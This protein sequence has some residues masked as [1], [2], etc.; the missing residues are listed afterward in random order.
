[1]YNTSMLRQNDFIV[2]IPIGVRFTLQYNASGNLE[3]VYVG[4]D[5]DR[6]DV[7]SDYL[8][9]FTQNKLVPLHINITGGT[10]WVKVVSYTQPIPKSCGRLPICV[11]SDLLCGLKENPNRYKFYGVYVESTTKIMQGFASIRQ[12]LSVSKFDTLNGWLA[13]VKPSSDTIESWLHSSSYPFVA[14][15]TMFI[16]FRGND[17]RF[18]PT[19]L[20]QR[21]IVDI[22]PYVDHHGYHN[23]DVKFND[24]SVT[25]PVSAK[26]IY[27]LAVGSVVIMD[28]NMSIMYSDTRPIMP[29]LAVVCDYC[30][31][32]ISF[33]DVDAVCC[34]NPHCSSHLATR[35]VKLLRDIGVVPK[36]IDYYWDSV[37]NDMI[38]LSDVFTLDAHNGNVYETT[39]NQVIKGILPLD[40]QISVASD[41]DTFVLCCGGNLKTVLHYVANPDSFAADFSV[42]PAD[43]MSLL[44]DWMSDEYN[45]IDLE[46]V[47]TSKSIELVKQQRLQ[48]VTPILHNRKICITG[49][50]SHGTHTEVADIL[51]SYGASVVTSIDNVTDCL[52]IGNTKEDVSGVLVRTA[53]TLNI[54]VVDEYTYFTK[55][56]IDAD[57]SVTLGG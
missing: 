46:S 6:T 36:S 22:H 2:P 19:A 34:D 4:F 43:S 9:V 18:V 40:L 13:T 28:N 42:Q 15:A 32:W 14:V 12:I 1:M 48:N 7:T 3:K 41:V 8:S 51:S 47:L 53:R 44:L 50:F 27:G 29:T 49:T 33:K 16:V 37:K 55:Y 31:R 56:G 35:A 26:A 54:P 5:S 25:L 11:E 39:I 52:L 45:A 20:T 57:L 21:K 17:V 10:T 38:T 23:V 30:G 24:C